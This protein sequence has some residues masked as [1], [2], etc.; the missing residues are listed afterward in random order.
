M[1]LEK[2]IIS[3]YKKAYCSSTDKEEYEKTYEE[4]IKKM[5]FINAEQY[6]RLFEQANK[7]RLVGKLIK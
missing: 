7:I 5:K 2:E 3:L 4:I 1:N 6:I